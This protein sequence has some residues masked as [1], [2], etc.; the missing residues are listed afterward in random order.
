MENF[1]INTNK[2]KMQLNAKNERNNNW[3]M[4]YGDKSYDAPPQRWKRRRRKQFPYLWHV[5]FCCFFLDK[6]IY[7]YVHMYIMYVICIFFSFI[8]QPTNAAFLSFILNIF[9]QQKQLQ[10]WRS[11]SGRRSRG[12]RGNKRTLNLHICVEF[13]Y[14]FAC[15]RGGLEAVTLTHVYRQ[16]IPCN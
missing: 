9:H 12:G 1:K 10:Y 2:R 5:I 7:L 13:R 8:S 4:V 14:R 15:R 11:E 6:Y 3:K 16:N